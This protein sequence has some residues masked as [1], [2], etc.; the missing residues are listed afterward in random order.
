MNNIIVLYMGYE[1]LLKKKKEKKI[2]KC[3][4]IR[5]Q[6]FNYFRMSV[7]AFDELL[8]TLVG[9]KLIKMDTNM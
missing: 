5:I 2:E 9:P 8:T 3:W 6:I 4:Y 7:S 1:L